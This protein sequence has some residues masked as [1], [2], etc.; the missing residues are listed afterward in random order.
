MNVCVSIRVQMYYWLSVLRFLILYV[1]YIYIYGKQILSFET[2]T[3]VARTGLGDGP[4]TLPEMIVFYSRL[5]LLTSTLQIDGKIVN[6]S[7]RSPPP[8]LCVR[9]DVDLDLERNHLYCSFFVGLTE[10]S[11]ES[12][13]NRTLWGS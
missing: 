9:L 12:K 6:E 13:S 10:D 3:G 4:P 5:E 2:R 11:C 1:Y 7:G 8:W